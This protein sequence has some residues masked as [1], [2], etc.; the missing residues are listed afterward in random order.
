M[1]LFWPCRHG[2]GRRSGRGGGRRGGCGCERGGAFYLAILGLLDCHE[3]R[4]LITLI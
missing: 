3:L 4:H 2:G 1:L